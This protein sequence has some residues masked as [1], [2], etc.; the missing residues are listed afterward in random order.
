MSNT[1]SWKLTQNGDTIS[2]GWDAA[3][4]PYLITGDWYW[5]EEMQ[6][7]GSYDIAYPDTGALYY[8]RDGQN[9]LMNCCEVR[10]RAWGLRQLVHTASFSPDGTPE[11]L[12]FTEKLMNNIAA[13]EG[14]WGI[15]NGTFYDPTP[16]SVWSWGRNVYGGGQPNP[17]YLPPAPDCFCDVSS[18]DCT[19]ILSGTQPF[20]QYYLMYALQQV[21]ELGYP[22]IFAAKNAFFK[23]ELHQILDPAYN[24]FLTA[25][26]YYGEQPIGSTNSCA[27]WAPANPFFTSWGSVLKSFTSAR[28]AASSF[29]Q[30]SS[31]VTAVEGGYHILAL[32][33]AAFLPG[34]DDAGLSGQ[35]A[36]N[37][38][39]ANVPSQNLLP[40]IP[41]WATVPRPR[42]ANEPRS[43]C[44]LNRDGVIDVLDVQQSISQT[45]QPVT[46]T[47]KLS[48]A[49]DCKGAT[50]QQVIQAALGGGCRTAQ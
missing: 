12:Y 28:Q 45:K 46:C 29:A 36:Y 49:A 17:L 35:E 30:V 27:A 21:Y 19:K 2:H 9:G 47:G 33:G 11:K 14:Y 50:T 31:D 32:G 48:D 26:Y 15:M 42:S 22:Q 16:A 40:N 34:I 23:N 37:W 39:V 18:Q 13:L 10:G 6:M 41:K 38:M 5:L 25:T 1:F 4:I 8:M 7:W 20:T 24:P 44:D 43:P 3:Y